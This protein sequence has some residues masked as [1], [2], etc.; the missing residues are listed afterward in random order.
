MSRTRC[1]SFVRGPDS[2]PSRRRLHVRSAERA[3]S[4]VLEFPH[5]NRSPPSTKA[6]PA[7]LSRT[8]RGSSA[9]NTVS[10]ARTRHLQRR[11]NDQD[12]DLLIEAGTS[13]SGLWTGPASGPAARC[14]CTARATAAT[15]RPQKRSQARLT[16]RAPSRNA[17]GAGS[18]PAR[19]RAGGSARLRCAAPPAERIGM[20][21]DVRPGELPAPPANAALEHAAPAGPGAPVALPGRHSRVQLAG[22]S[23]P[24]RYRSR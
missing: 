9:A 15:L 17:G 24:S 23:A 22:I 10:C 11:G 7:P 12:L 20:R 18:G 14:R 21:L 3:E 16:A 13:R 5:H 1:G 19:R 8:M 4:P 2:A 6:Q